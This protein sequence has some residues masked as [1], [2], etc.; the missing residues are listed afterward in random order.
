M[1]LFQRVMA[2]M[3]KARYQR[4]LGCFVICL[5]QDFSY[6]GNFKGDQLEGEFRI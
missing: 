3:T 6:V 5:H 2:V 1:L 4:R